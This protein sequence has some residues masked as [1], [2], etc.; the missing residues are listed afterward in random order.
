MLLIHGSGAPNV[1]V[2]KTPLFDKR[3]FDPSNTWYIY[4]NTPL[5]QSL[6]KFVRFPI[7]TS[8]ESN[9]PRLLL[10]AVDVQEANPVGCVTISV[11]KSGFLFLLTIG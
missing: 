3:F 5:R 2:P 4:D 10:V 7:S 8:F 1:F 11:L 6:E 9:E